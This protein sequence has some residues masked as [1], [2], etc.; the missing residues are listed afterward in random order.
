[1]ARQEKDE[2]QLQLARTLKYIPWCEQYE[3]MVSGMLYDSF[4]PELEASRFKAKA[5]IHDYN[6]F[7]PSGPDAS[8][9]TLQSQRLEKLKGVLGHVGADD[10]YIEAPFYIDYGCNISIGPRFYAAFNFTVIDCALVEIGARV[11][12]GP[13]VSIFTATHETEVQSRRDDIE[14][15]KPVRIGDDCWIGGGAIILPGVTV[16][17]GCTIAAGSV[18]T[19]DIPAWSVAMGSPARVVRKVTPVE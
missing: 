11:M 17:K 1:M 19:K 2:S 16:G 8:F 6:H 5:F 18:V 10:V 4:I 13:N 15:A 14:F 12:I 3:R 7:F 9:K